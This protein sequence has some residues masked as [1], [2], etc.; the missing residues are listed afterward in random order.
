MSKAGRGCIQSIW[1]LHNLVTPDY[2]PEGVIEVAFKHLKPE[3][4]PT[5]LQPHTGPQLGDAAE[6]AL[7]CVQILFKVSKACVTTQNNRLHDLFVSRITR[8][9]HSVC[10]WMW[11]LFERELASPDPSVARS[12]ASYMGQAQLLDGITQANVAVLEAFTLDK[13]FLKLL[14]RLWVGTDPRGEVVMEWHAT[15]EGLSQACPIAQLVV[16]VLSHD[17]S[18][19]RLVE[20][21]STGDISSPKRFVHAFLKRAQRFTAGEEGA[22][23]DNMKLLILGAAHLIS[24]DPASAFLFRKA[25]YSS[26]MGKAVHAVCKKTLNIPSFSAHAPAITAS[27]LEAISNLLRTIASYPSHSAQGYGIIISAGILPLAAR[28]IPYISPDDEL[29]RGHFKYIVDAVGVHAFYPPVRKH[30]IVTQ[31]PPAFHASLLEIPGI[32]TT[33]EKFQKMVEHANIPRQTTVP[34]GAVELCDNPSCNGTR[35][36]S[37]KACARCSAFVYCSPG[38]QKQDWKERHRAECI[39]ARE[40]HGTR[41]RSG[42]WYS[43]ATRSYYAKVVAYWYRNALSTLHDGAKQQYPTMAFREMLPILEF[44]PGGVNAVFTPL[45]PVN[46]PTTTGR[47]A[48][49][50]EEVGHNLQQKWLEPR[51]SQ[52]VQRYLAEASDDGRMRLVESTFQWRERTTMSV[53][54][55]LEKSRHGEYTSRYCIPIYEEVPVVV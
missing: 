23:I 46:G 13:V 5:R 29:S 50:L 30:L 28:F 16:R 53:L 10:L 31:Y 44:S 17:F 3:L 15:E 54:I 4:V 19:E 12:Q 27:L 33:W 55:M 48:P 35:R 47:T 40:D 24:K 37:P 51:L 34:F 21:I 45:T 39:Y 7:P 9:A 20:S 11:Y 2:C 14:V 25:G 6:R 32:S 38:C 52:M 49:F 43:H 41:R 36:D 8:E 42:N 1:N 26:L 22:Q 18:R